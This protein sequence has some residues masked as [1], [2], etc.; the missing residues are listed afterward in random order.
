MA[1][2]AQMT[3]EDLKQLILELMHEE[4]SKGQGDM[5]NS[6]LALESEEAP[7][8]RSLEEVFASIER[9]RWTPPEGSPSGGDM[10]RHIRDQS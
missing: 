1:T 4:T 10:L 6:P 2:I 3:I 9:N 5:E 7:D 8:Q